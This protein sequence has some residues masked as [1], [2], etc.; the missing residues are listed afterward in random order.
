MAFAPKEC[1]TDQRTTRVPAV[2]GSPGH[3]QLLFA[4][5]TDMQKLRF[6]HSHSPLR[7]SDTHRVFFLLIEILTNVRAFAF[8]RIG[9]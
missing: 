4:F 8:I 7:I 6:S 1:L 3:V 9:Q 5:P 2:P